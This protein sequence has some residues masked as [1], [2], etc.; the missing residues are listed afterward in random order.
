[1]QKIREK[2]TLNNNLIPN[3]NSPP[4]AKLL[5]ITAAPPLPPPLQP[6]ALPKK[7]FARR[8]SFVGSK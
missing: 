1:M 7:H 3:I 5:C 4:I 6:P 2:K 8:R